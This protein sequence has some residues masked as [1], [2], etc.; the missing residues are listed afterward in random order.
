[1]KY[2]IISKYSDKIFRMK[3]AGTPS[4]DLIL[5]L[6]DML[7]EIESRILSITGNFLTSPGTRIS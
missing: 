2:R 6:R 5:E 4:E 3:E 7:D 1:M